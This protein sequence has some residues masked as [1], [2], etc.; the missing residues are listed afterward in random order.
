[1]SGNEGSPPLPSKIKNIPA[2]LK[3]R[4][5]WVAYTLGKV[6]KNPATGGAAKTN[7]S[8]TWGSFEQA[9]RLWQGR[10]GNGIGGIGFVFTPDDPYCGVDLDKCRNPETGEIEAWARDIIARLKSY[11][12]LSPSGRG[13]HILVRAKLPGTGR[14]KGRVEMYDTGRYFTM[15]GLHLEETPTTVEDRQAEITALHNEIFRRGKVTRS[16]PAPFPL[17]EETQELSALPDTQRN[18]SLTQLAGTLR[19]LRLNQG[20]IERG[21]QA[22][23]QAICEPPL[24]EDE[25]SRIARSIAQKPP[26]LTRKGDPWA[27]V[28]ALGELG[29][30]GRGIS[31]KALKERI[32][33]NQDCSE[34]YA[35][36]IVRKACK[37]HLIE[38][39]KN[40]FKGY[41]I[42][43]PPGGLPQGERNSCG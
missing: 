39:G 41:R 22:L 4:P 10:R 40:G 18:V 2:E 13:V 37:E 33:D 31:H 25:V 17:G 12:E 30:Q 11:T 29:G 42:R 21:L 35:E 16:G 6:P 24:P 5:Q 32:M 15:T 36:R 14:K 20:G 3:A 23:N 38:K 34:S 9:V 1:M 43:R 27:A 8:R 19:R 28:Q 26:G 7:D